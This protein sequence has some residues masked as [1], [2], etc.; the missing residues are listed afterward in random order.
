MARYVISNKKHVDV[1]VDVDTKP[2]RYPV[3][4]YK[5]FRKAHSRA[6][7]REVKRSFKNPQQYSIIDTRTQEIVR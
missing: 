1:P 5:A 2:S 3:L 4:A 6:K 7:A